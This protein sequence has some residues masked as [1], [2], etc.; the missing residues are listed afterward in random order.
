MDHAGIQTGTDLDQR[1]ALAVEL[2]GQGHIQEAITLYE[3]VARQ[4]PNYGK[5]RFNLAMLLTERG[6]LEEAEQHCRAAAQALPDYPDAWGLHAYLLSLLQRTP[7]SLEAA[8][9]AVRLGFPRKRL[10]G[11]LKLEPAAL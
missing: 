2:E 1:F 6:R 10:A 11:L 5:A 8:R 7:E 3:S 9:K 4:A